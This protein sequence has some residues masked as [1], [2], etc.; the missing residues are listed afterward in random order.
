MKCKCGKCGWEWESKL[1]GGGPA[2][3]P[4]CKRYDWK[5]QRIGKDG[6]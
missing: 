3:C 2:C 6:K 5:I 1:K 4:R